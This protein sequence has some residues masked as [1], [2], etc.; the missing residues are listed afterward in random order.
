VDRRRYTHP[1]GD[2]L[3]GH[4]DAALAA[5][6]ERYG[7]LVDV[8]RPLLA[9]FSLGATEAALLAQRD[10][11]RFP[12]VALLEG[13]LDV[14][15][16]QS[17]DQFAWR[18]GTH[19]LFGCGSGWC[20]PPAQAA[21]RRIETEGIEARVAFADVGHRDTPPL[22]EALRAEFAWFIDGDPRWAMETQ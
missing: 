3:R 14:W 15:W 17:I 2:A 5:L 20:T 7:D 8:R 1:G 9:G 19:V 21:S 4:I 11:E 6:A 10:G 18:G 12:R 13:G 22:Q 16:P